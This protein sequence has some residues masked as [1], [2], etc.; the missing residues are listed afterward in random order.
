MVKEQEMLSLM[1]KYNTTNRKTIK[2]N[3]KQILN[4]NDIKTA[5]IIKDLNIN[6]EKAY[7]WAKPSSN[8]IPMLD[9]AL[10]LAIKYNFKVT[11][12]LKPIN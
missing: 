2:I 1:E 6:R 11:D 12:L 7:A 10:K 4:S 5:D 8:N 3:L 9:D